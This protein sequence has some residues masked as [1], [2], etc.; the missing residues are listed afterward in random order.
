[1]H[2]EPAAI[3][4]RGARRAHPTHPLAAVSGAVE[5]FAI[6]L[7][8]LRMSPSMLRLC[9]CVSNATVCL[10]LRQA[11]DEALR[12]RARHAHAHPPRDAPLGR[13]HPAQG[14]LE[15][16]GPPPVRG[17]GTR[18]TPNEIQETLTALRKVPHHQRHQAEGSQ[19]RLRRAH[20]APGR[21]VEVLVRLAQRIAVLARDFARARS[22]HVAAPRDRVLEFYSIL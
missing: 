15:R 12:V 14:A 17:E 18:G 22:H 11:P 16:Q 5:V 6:E 19:Q 13:G 7:P 3:A 20:R 4:E 2:T 1:M 9:A 21:A 10:H 8:R